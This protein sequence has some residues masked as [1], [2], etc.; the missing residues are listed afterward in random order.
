MVAAQ[1]ERLLAGL[2][3]NEDPVLSEP[4]QLRSITDPP[5]R[6]G[7]QIIALAD[8]WHDAALNRGVRQRDAKR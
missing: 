3:R 5:T 7:M 6:R 2:R 4:I 1:T 8:A